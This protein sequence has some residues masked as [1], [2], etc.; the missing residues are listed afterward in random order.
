MRY[1]YNT[2]KQLAKKSGIR[3][4]DLLALANQNDPFYVGTTGDIEMAEWFSDLWTRATAGARGAVHLRRI[5]YWIVSQSPAVT[6][7]NGEAYENTE[8][9]WQYLILTSKKARY[10][11]YVE[12]AQIADNKNPRPHENAMYSSGQLAYEIGLPKLHRPDVEIYNSTRADVQPYH[13]ELWC[14]K[15]TM[16]DVLLPICHEYAAN[17]VTFEGEVS[18]TACYDLI[19]R[20]TRASKPARI[21]YIS[22][23]DPAGNSMPVAMARKV[24]YL[25]NN[26]EQ[27]HDVKVTPLALT[28]DQVR[29]YDLP[30]I[31]IKETEKRAA[32]F[33][34]AFGNGAVELDALEALY[35][36]TLRSLV[37][38]AMEEYHSSEAEQS[39]ARQIENLRQAIRLQINAITGKYQTEIEALTGMVEELQAI[40]VNPADYQPRQ[41]DPHVNHEDSWLFDSERQ[42]IDQIDFYKAHKSGS[43]AA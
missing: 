28:A 36:G 8:R 14:E 34:E 41:Y 1:D 30:R 32:R 19:Q 27:W 23:F 26:A 21:W 3:V 22:D 37:T 5:H 39:R 12:I 9:C 43:N 11:G 20:V 31:P 42:Y 10:L 25:L 4:S 15:S 35:P 18:I 38:Q 2:I 16:N 29:Q 33:E 40:H 24:E 6:M 17:L 13:L 7:P